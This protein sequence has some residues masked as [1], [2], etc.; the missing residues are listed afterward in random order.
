MSTVAYE[1]IRMIQ[2]RINNSHRKLLGFKTPKD[3][4]HQS[5]KK[6]ESR[7]CILLKL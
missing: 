5:V 1:E 3:E 7:A 2:K 4:Y 6:V